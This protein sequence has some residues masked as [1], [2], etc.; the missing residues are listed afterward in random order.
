MIAGAGLLFG[1]TGNLTDLERI[2]APLENSNAWS[3]AAEVR[4]VEHTIPTPGS[5]ETTRQTSGPGKSELRVAG[6]IPLT[7][8]PAITDPE[9]KYWSFPSE[10]PSSED[11]QP[12]L[13]RLPAIDQP[14]E[15]LAFLM[16]PQAIDI[17]HLLRL[18][19]VQDSTAAT[20]AE[21]VS[22]IPEPESEPAETNMTTESVATPAPVEQ[23]EAVV[24]T[25]KPPALPT[26][27]LSHEEQRLLQAVISETSSATTGVL[28]DA[29]LN[30]QATEKIRAAFSLA[31]RRAHYAARQKLIEVLRMVSQ[32]KDA[33]QGVPER[34]LALA[35]GLRALD[36]A[37]DYAP[38]GAELEAEMN[39]EV[40]A[41]SHR[42]PI[43]K[44]IEHKKLLPQQIMAMYYRY[45][46]LK[47]A[48][49]VAGE[50]AGS[51]ALHTLGKIHSQLER[52][53]PQR[54]RLAS[55]R[56]IA[57]QQAALLAHQQNHVAA[58]ELGVLLAKA[59][60][61]AE[62][63][64]LILQV[65]AREPNAIVYRNLAQIQ[66][67][68]GYPRQAAMNRA[69]AQHLT[70]QGAS[71]RQQVPWVS[72]EKFARLGNYGQPTTRFTNATAMT[73]QPTRPTA[74]S[75]QR[76]PRPFPNWR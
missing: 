26:G 43:A 72:P 6:I 25:E 27:E 45:A 74:L 32:A 62:A 44:Q 53:E 23:P 8:L 10:D 48:L 13:V 7:E 54:H 73:A 55:R 30:E 19:L 2:D 70:R 15:P 36:E 63:E 60:H 11:E 68:M 22:A 24:N 18:P 64:K 3:Q 38:R 29:R 65:A 58:H 33:Q 9:E 59:G 21:P 42:T 20:T 12:L 17:E 35:A 5:A 46:Q 71:G 4:L 52:L 49:A 51:M 1:C 28:T 34:T 56:A 50:P 75:G 67:Q 47:L 41:A 69:Q 40:L 76:P 31:N 66:E 14:S 61:L 57:F 16:A 37:E 39:L